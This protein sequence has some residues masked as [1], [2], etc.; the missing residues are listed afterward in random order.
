ML[1]TDWCNRHYDVDAEP[2]RNHGDGCSM[3]PVSVRIDLAGVEKAYGHERHS[4]LSVS[5][6]TIF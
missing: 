3:V 1:L 5:D 4:L 2:I 6:R